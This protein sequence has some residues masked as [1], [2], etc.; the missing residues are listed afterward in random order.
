MYNRDKTKIIISTFLFMY[1]ATCFLG[2]VA[3]VRYVYAIIV[4]VPFMFGLLN[5]KKVF[6]I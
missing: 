4:C 6:C 2:P 1:F 3:I 5:I